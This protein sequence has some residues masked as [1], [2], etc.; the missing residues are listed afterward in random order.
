MRRLSIRLSDEV[1]L[2]LVKRY[3][4]RGLSKAV[5]ELLRKALFEHGKGEAG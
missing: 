1:Y 2:E 5:D 3:G 4:V